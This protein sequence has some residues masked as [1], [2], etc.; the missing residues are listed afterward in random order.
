M[1]AKSIL[2]QVAGPVGYAVATIATDAQNFGA[3][4]EDNAPVVVKLFKDATCYVKQCFGAE[5][6][7]EETVE[8][9]E[10]VA[11]AATDVADKASVGGSAKDLVDENGANAKKYSFWDWLVFGLTVLAILTSWT[12]NNNVDVR[13]KLGYSGVNATAGILI[14]LI[15]IFGIFMFG[16]WLY[17]LFLLVPL[18]QMVPG[19]NTPNGAY[20]IDGI[21]RSVSDPVVPA[22]N[23][24]ITKYLAMLPQYFVSPSVPTAAAP[25]VPPAQF[26]QFYY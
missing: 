8:D 16:P 7:E 17:F 25:I 21:K 19:F 11:D 24:F 18:F 13:M 6:E 1:D 12:L 10:E 2:G 4:T 26:G 14:S 20:W 9:V 5:G 23:K 3:G 15:S 22:D